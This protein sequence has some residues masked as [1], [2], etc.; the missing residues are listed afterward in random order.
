MP[1]SLSLSKLHAGAKS[2][3][4]SEKSCYM[5]MM[6]EENRDRNLKKNG[7]SL[8]EINVWSTVPFKFLAS[9]ICPNRNCDKNFALSFWEIKGKLI[10]FM[11][12][13]CVSR[14]S[15]V[16]FASKY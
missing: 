11:P 6:F 7:K 13:S 1:T 14:V 5:Q 12:Q 8:G 2:K 10:E 3:T 15:N 9:G 4:G 16:C